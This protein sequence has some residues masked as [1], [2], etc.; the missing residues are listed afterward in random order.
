MFRKYC[1]QTQIKPKAQQELFVVI[2]FTGSPR[3]GRQDGVAKTNNIV[4][5]TV[6]DSIPVVIEYEFTQSGRNIKSVLDSMVEWG[7][8]HRKITFNGA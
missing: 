3:W 7:L 6:H 8:E 1:Q 2:V 4:K 5:R